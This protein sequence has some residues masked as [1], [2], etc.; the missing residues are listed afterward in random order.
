MNFFKKTKR[1]FA[2]IIT[3]CL[4][5]VSIPFTAFASDFKKNLEIDSFI[6]SKNNNYIVPNNFVDEQTLPEEP[7][8]LFGLD[9][10]SGSTRVNLV[11]YGWYGAPIQQDQKTG[12]FDTYKN[13]LL[14]IVGTITDTFGGIVIS[15]ADLLIS[16][17]STTEIATARTMISYTYPTKQGQ[18]Y[19]PST[20]TWNTYFEST[21]RN[22]FKHYY[23]IWMDTNKNTRQYARDFVTA[24]GYA[25]IKVDRA[26][27]Y[28]NN[29]Y[30][31]DKAYQNYVQGKRS[32]EDWNS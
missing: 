31:M 10:G 13:V 8:T 16:S 2:T 12:R 5:T 17:V 11:T 22:V 25:P 26:P 24:G 29:T 1:L 19:S 32:E 15:V 14:T 18:V 28:L 30:I 3:L 23:A 9:P 21:N 27:N 7:I 20:R 4:L 6:E